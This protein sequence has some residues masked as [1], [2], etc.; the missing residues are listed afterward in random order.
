MRRIEGERPVPLKLISSQ[1]FQTGVLN[2][3]YA[4][5]EPAGQAGP[6]RA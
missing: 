5:S 4:V 6:E 1:A 3:L 2:L